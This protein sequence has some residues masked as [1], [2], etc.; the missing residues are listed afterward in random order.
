MTYHLRVV[1]AAPVVGR[2]SCRCLTLSTL[3]GP[4]W[5]WH[6]CLWWFGVS[7][8]TQLSRPTPLAISWAG[9][10]RKLFRAPNA[11]HSSV[12]LRRWD[13]VTARIPHSYQLCEL[14][15]IDIAIIVYLH[16]REVAISAT[17]IFLVS[18]FSNNTSGIKK[19]PSVSNTNGEWLRRHALTLTVTSLILPS[20]KKD[21]NNYNWFNSR[22]Y[23]KETIKT[24]I[25]E[26][27]SNTTIANNSDIATWWILETLRRYPCT[28][29][30]KF[31]K[32]N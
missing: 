8:L 2:T 20:G 14:H 25:H 17:C 18:I 10:Y 12:M 31:I 32:Q 28:N 4:W 26:S 30:Y 16:Q 21:I 15:D 22:R 7:R 3:A 5:W 27:S 6:S 23:N 19:R 9:K 11:I 29:L 1:I 13:N 24:Q